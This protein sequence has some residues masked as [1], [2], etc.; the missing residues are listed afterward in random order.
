MVVKA[1]AAQAHRPMVPVTT[2]C[3]GPIIQVDSE[4][5]KPTATLVVTVGQQLLTD[6]SPIIIPGDTQPARHIQQRGRAMNL[7]RQRRQADLHEHGHAHRD[8]AR[9]SALQRLRSTFCQTSNATLTINTSQRASGRCERMV[10]QV[11]EEVVAQCRAS[12]R[13]NRPRWRATAGSARRSCGERTSTRRP[14]T[15]ARPSKHRSEACRKI[16][17]DQP[18]ASSTSTASPS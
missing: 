7:P 10:T 9:L 1:L 11:I 14:P 18:S 17:T 12:R 16:Q 4:E 15:C 5:L 13:S 3:G 8:P 2:G 6:G